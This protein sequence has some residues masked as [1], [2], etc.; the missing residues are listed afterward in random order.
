M[1]R[2]FR[3]RQRLTNVNRRLRLESLEQRIVFDGAGSDAA[4]TLTDRPNSDVCAPPASTPDER[5][6]TRMSRLAV[7]DL[8]KRLEIDPKRI[9]IARVEEHEWPSGCL[10]IEKRDSVCTLALVRG[11]IVRL[12]AQ[13]QQFEYH[14]DRERRVVLVPRRE[15]DP[16]PEPSGVIADKFRVAQ[17]SSENKLDVLANDFPGIT[18]IKAPQ[19]SSVTETR[20]G[21]KVRIAE[22]GLL[23][24]YTPPMN[25]VGEDAFQYTV[26][27]G[28]SGRVVVHVVARETPPPPPTDDHSPLIDVRL[29]I[30]DEAGNQ[31]RSVEI[32]QTFFVEVYVDDL[33]RE[34]RGV[35]GSYL[36]VAFNSAAQ[37]AGEIEYN[38]TY[39]NGKSGALTDDTI[40][41]VGAFTDSVPTLG[42]EPQLLVRIPFEA[43]DEGTFTLRTNPADERPAH[44]MT[45]FGV[46]AAVNLDRVRFG[47]ASL[48]IVNGYHNEADPTDVNGDASTTPL[49]ALNI[50]NVINGSGAGEMRTK[51]REFLRHEAHEVAHA[52]RMFYDVNKDKFLTALDP[53]IVI[54][55]LNSEAQKLADRLA[56]QVADGLTKLEEKLEDRLNQDSNPVLPPDL[57]KI[58]DRL[59]ERR[60]DKGRESDQND[61]TDTLNNTDRCLRLVDAVGRNVPESTLVDHLT[62]LAKDF[63]KH[64][65]ADDVDDFFATLQ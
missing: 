26:D 28:P 33:R 55:R 27:N 51:L 60:D 48:K 22:N 3:N 14:T 52:A 19:I 2:L 6:A 8:A 5:P 42:G 30:T 17:E 49:D 58:I 23:L 46:N 15:P 64:Q 4:C 62:D 10:G 21:G 43:T 24:L 7:E 39:P 54:N 40:D 50:I 13:G 35:F 36:D 57:G 56:Q 47:D 29:Q 25:F 31:V 20:A 9:E 41:E 63:C 45:L 38:S 32:G 44:E 53:L 12:N 11:F 61:A 59:V 16:A 18:F 37:I 1:I 34:G 65:S